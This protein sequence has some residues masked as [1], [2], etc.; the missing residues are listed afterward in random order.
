MILIVIT[1]KIKIIFNQNSFNKILIFK[2]ITYKLINII[3]NHFNNII[4]KYIKTK[5]K[6]KTI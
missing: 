6:F 2:I 4:H 5:L 3:D 1:F